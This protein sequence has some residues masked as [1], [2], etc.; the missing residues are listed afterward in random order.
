MPSPISVLAW[1]VANVTSSV[2]AIA[3]RFMPDAVLQLLKRVRYVNTVRSFW[4]PEADIMGALVD[5]GDYV[6]DIGA[7][8]GWYTRVLS[9]AVGAEGLVHSFE[10]IPSTFSLLSYCTRRLR[11][12]NVSLFNCAASRV[13]GTALMTVPHYPG[14]GENYHQA[15]LVTGADEIACLRQLSVELRTVDSVLPAPPR[16]ITF[17]KCDVEGHEAEALEGATRTIERDRPALCIEVTGD[18]D[19]SGSPSHQI[20][21]SLARWGYEPYWLSSGHLTRRR[22]GDRSVNY[23]FLTEK[24]KSRLNARGLLPP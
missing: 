14:G 8:A 4:S 17:I 6:L 24:H 22:A 19:I 21:S 2:K 3:L 13:N 5:K 15:T 11:L 18:P 20:V 16:P 1:L 7:Y 23:F 12:R 10:P 9:N